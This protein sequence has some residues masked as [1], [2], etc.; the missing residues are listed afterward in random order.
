MT[1]LLPLKEKP[2][3]PA[4]AADVLRGLAEFVENYPATGVLLTVDLAVAT[5]KVPA[6]AKR[7]KRPSTP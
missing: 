2:L 3:T 6:P 1:P 5:A 4:E 7:T